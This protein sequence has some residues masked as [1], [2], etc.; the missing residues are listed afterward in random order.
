[1]LHSI[2]LLRYIFRVQLNLFGHV[3]RQVLKL[4]IRRLG[5]ET[6]LTQGYEM[7]ACILYLGVRLEGLI[8]WIGKGE[9]KNGNRE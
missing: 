3:R 9:Q 8:G 1:M 7:S 4:A 6:S 2:C 5:L